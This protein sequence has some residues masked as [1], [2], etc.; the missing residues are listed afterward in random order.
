MYHKILHGLDGSEGSFKALNEAIRLAKSYGLEL[1]SLTVEELPKYPETVS[2]I[3]EE[4]EAQ[5]GKY[6]A[7]IAKAKEIAAGEKVELISH[8]TL[9][10]EVKSFIDL[11]EKEGFDLLVVGFMGHSALYDR[12]MG[13]TCGSL[14]RLAPCSVLVVK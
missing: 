10:H 5:N 6:D 13:S 11:I 1:H 14:V 9:G 2:E 7:V 8:V 3:S 4:R 12:V